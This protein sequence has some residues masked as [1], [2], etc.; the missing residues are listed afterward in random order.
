LRDSA[1]VVDVF[2]E[3][4]VRKNDASRG[5]SGDVSG[6][7][8]ESE[9]RTSVD[10]WVLLDRCPFYPEGGGQVSDSGSILGTFGELRVTDVQRNGE[11]IVVR[12]GI[13]RVVCGA[14]VCNEAEACVFELRAI[15][16]PCYCACLSAITVSLPSLSLMFLCC[17]P[18]RIP[19]LDAAAT[20]SL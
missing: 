8:S 20:L 2:V 1:T 6:S 5:G 15:R 10:A 12:C 13:G 9:S 14:H 19:Y 3:D 7:K 17:S 18:I 16:S 11:G 4:P